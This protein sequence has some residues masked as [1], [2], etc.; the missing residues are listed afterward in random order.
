[1]PTRPRSGAGA[2]GVEGWTATEGTRRLVRANSAKG[3]GALRGKPLAP[4]Q[5]EI[6]RRNALKNNNAQYLDPTHGCGWTAGQL[7]LLGV[8]PDRR[9]AALTGRSAGAVRP[10]REQPA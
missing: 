2:F 5:V 10:Q 1:V 6:R 3:A 8:H 4:E 7:A 9:V